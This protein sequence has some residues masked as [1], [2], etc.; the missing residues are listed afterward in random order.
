MTSDE[1]M[2][3]VETIALLAR[4]QSELV[5]AGAA[6][7]KHTQLVLDEIVAKANSI[8]P[9]RVVYP[10]DLSDDENLVKDLADVIGFCEATHEE[11][12]GIWSRLVENSTP[13]VTWQ[14]H[15]G[16]GREIGQ[17]DG[18]PVFVTLSFVTIA[19]YRVCFYEATSVVTDMDM[20]RAYIDGIAPEGAKNG[21]RVNHSDATNFVNI[22]PNDWQSKVA[23]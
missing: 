11:V 16:H 4:N 6:S 10:I 18:R 12:F 7:A 5:E 21:D 15:G 9:S 13:K 8:R 14:Q 3:I 2:K 20:V 22:L 1:I 19:G 17:I 23:A